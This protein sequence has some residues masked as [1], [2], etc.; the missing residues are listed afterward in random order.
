M[1]QR[2][3]DMGLGVPFNIASYSLSTCILAR[4]CG[5][6][7]GEFVYTLGVITG[8]VSLVMMETQQHVSILHPLHIWRSTQRVWRLVHWVGDWMLHTMNTIHCTH[9]AEWT[10]GYHATDSHII[11]N[12][13]ATKKLSQLVSKK[14][15]RRMM[16]DVTWCAKRLDECTQYDQKC[17]RSDYSPPKMAVF[18]VAKLRS[19]PNYKDAETQVHKHVP[20][21]LRDDVLKAM[22]RVYYVNQFQKLED[23]P[24]LQHCVSMMCGPIR[25]D[26]WMLTGCW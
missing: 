2:S 22:D 21:P 12:R 16:C 5:L 17:S 24:S 6:K 26:D 18:A 23:R 1:Y 20:P 8:V 19:T 3:C 15:C 25:F 4:V 11:H 14:L 7:P 10:P 9:S 13:H